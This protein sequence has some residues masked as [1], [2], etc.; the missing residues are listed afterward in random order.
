MQTRREISSLRQ[1]L[2]Q[3]LCSVELITFCAA[4]IQR[5]ETGGNSI[6]PSGSSCISYTGPATT[7]QVFYTGHGYRTS[8][9]NLMSMYK[10]TRGY[11]AEDIRLHIPHRHRH[12]L[13]SFKPLSR[14]KL[15]LKDYVILQKYFETSLGN[16]HQQT[17]SI[18]T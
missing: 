13:N 8:S 11:N 16:F 10:T 2:L 9:N 6:L 4:C 12:I 7:E 1:R 3:H 18:K 15:H 17:R 5:H 14:Y